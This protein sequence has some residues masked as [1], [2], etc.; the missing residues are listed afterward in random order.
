VD[1]TTR[2]TASASFDT[3]AVLQRLTVQ[4]AEI[5]RQLLEI[6]ADDYATRHAL[7]TAQDHLRAE[8]A[9]LRA[10]RPIS[11]DER[12]RLEQRLALLRRRQDELFG[13]RITARQTAA[14]T[15]AGTG[16][17]AMTGADLMAIDQAILAAGGRDELRH[18]IAVL[19]QRLS[20]G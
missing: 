9:V 6:P 20:A 15:G 3:H 13:G 14:S 11:D 8:A 7:R 17:G 5:Q 4:L 16:G 10:E 12:S 19:E 1:D 18:E 2:S